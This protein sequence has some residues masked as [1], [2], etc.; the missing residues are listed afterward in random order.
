VGDGGIFSI[1][2]DMGVLT[3]YIAISVCTYQGMIYYSSLKYN[4]QG[5]GNGEVYW[6]I[7]YF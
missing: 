6:H 1:L 5:V 7:I 2:F 4:F 3:N